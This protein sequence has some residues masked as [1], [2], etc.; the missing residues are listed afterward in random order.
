MAAARRRFWPS[1]SSARLRSTRSW[2]RPCRTQRFYYDVAQIAHP[3]PLAA[4]AK[5]VPASQI[6]WG[7]DYP[8]RFGNEYVKALAAFGFSDSDL[9][10][11]DRENALALLPRLKAG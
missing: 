3:V 8:F 6:L 9:G 4:L 1:A 7:T 2:R 5:F 11:I 10:K